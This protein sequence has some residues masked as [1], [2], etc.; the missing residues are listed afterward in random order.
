MLRIATVFPLLL[1]ACAVAWQ[2]DLDRLRDDVGALSV[3]HERAPR[4][5]STDAE[6]DRRLSEPLSAETL[7][8]AARERNP[9][10]R[11]AAA[12]ARAGLEEVRRAG[13]WDDPRLTLRTEGVPLRRPSSLNRAEENALGLS[14]TIPFPGNPGLRS[15]AAL[16]DAEAMREAVRERELDLAAMVRKAHAE[17][18]A[19][20]RELEIHREHI[21]LLEGFERA[22]EVRFRAGAAMQQD[23]LKPQLEQVMLHSEVFE[24]E[25]RLGAT[26]AELNRLLH[27][28]PAA[29]LG[30]PVEPAAPGDVPAGLAERALAERPE[31]RA[32]ELKVRAT[33]AALRLAGREATLPD[34]ELGVEYMQMP[35]EPDAW[36]GMFS[37]N[38]PWFSGKR[39]AEERRLEHQLRADEAAADAVRG[40][41]LFEVRDA[42]LRLAAARQILDL[43][44]RELV[45]KS[46]Q[47][48]DAVRAG[49]EK[50]RASFLDLLDAERSLRDVRLRQAQAAAQ[51]ASAFAD[52]ER[53][54]GREL[55]RTP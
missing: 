32:A 8:G 45:P 46:A 15:E 48:V 14:Q 21:R 9:A 6:L 40:R 10:L 53:A 11:E 31:L 35:G 16:R 28:P 49:Y 27:R 17:Y 20:W 41:I 42:E 24:I 1:S 38:L 4:A 50:D 34:F 12:R 5:P 30:P 47:S 37:L 22:S 26:R 23:V 18:W 13:A 44:A 39:R 25:R 43:A 33:Q 52:L 19:L 29:P 51:A 2:D 54:A 7:L 55:R 3:R 36:G